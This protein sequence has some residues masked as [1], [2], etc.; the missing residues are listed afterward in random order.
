[1]KK[2]LRIYTKSI[3]MVFC[4]LSTIL[5]SGSVLKGQT[6]KLFAVSDMVR[7]F[8]DGYNLP[9]V[10]DTIDLF[11]IHGEIIS[12]QFVIYTRT[13]LTDVSI[14]VT[15]LK[16]NQTG[17]PFPPDA[18]T[19]NFVGSIPLTKN[20]PNQPVS[21]LTRQAPAKYPEY[22]M[23]EKQMNIPTKNV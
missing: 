1:M 2:E 12:G 6:V 13:D 7:V 5:M 18:I 3:K 19:W 17:T 4:L 10:Y 9:Q 20:T 14:E 16:K 22:L 8:E 21:A 15:P 23:N 11:G